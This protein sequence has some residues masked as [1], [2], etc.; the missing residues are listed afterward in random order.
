MPP[1][2]SSSLAETQSRAYLIYSEWGPDSR[3]PRDERLA[4]RFPDIPEDTRR[5]WMAEFDR[6]EA[7][8]W[9]AAE[10]GGPRTGSFETF[11]RQMRDSFPFMSDEA[12]RRAWSRAGYYAWH[13]GYY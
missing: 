8:I 4:D 10:A 2:R 11:A 1:S 12:L 6:V 13:E 9:K 5:A 7:A 3:I